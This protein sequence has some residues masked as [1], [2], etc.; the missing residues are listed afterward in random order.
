MSLA[1]MKAVLLSQVG[2]YD[3]PSVPNKYSLWYASRHGN[4]YRTGDGCDMGLSWAAW[5]AGE[6]SN[7]GEFAYVPDHLEWYRARKQTSDTPEVGRIFFGDW[8]N[9]G[10]PNHI[11]WVL[12]VVSKTHIRNVEFNHN[13]SVQ[14]VD[15]TIPSQWLSFGVPLYNSDGMDDIAEVVSLGV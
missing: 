14:I 9:N 2:T 6:G 4:V 7:V 12:E 11:A 13:N 3:N 1:T 5:K 10:I 15:R 8:N